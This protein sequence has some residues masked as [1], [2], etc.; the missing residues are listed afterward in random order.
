V[1][2]GR[3]VSGSWA[4]VANTTS[5]NAST[6]LR[7]SGD[8]FD[9]VEEFLMLAWEVAEEGLGADFDVETITDA[10]GGLSDGNIAVFIE[11]R[12]IHD[13]GGELGGHGKWSD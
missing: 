8:A 12:E 10:A 1:S 2:S 5:G 11:L 13:E 7:A 3:E 6:V 9:G 4:F